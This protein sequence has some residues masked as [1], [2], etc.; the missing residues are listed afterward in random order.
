MRNFLALLF[1]C[2]AIAV[3]AAT[4]PVGNLIVANSI[5]LTGDLTPATITSDQNDYAPTNLTTSMN[6]RLSSDASRNITGLAGGSAGRTVLVH[7]VGSFSIVLRDQSSASVAANRFAIG[8]DVTLSANTSLLLQYDG[9]ASRW[10]AVGA[11]G[12]GGGG[13]AWGSI[14]GTLSNQTDLN[15]ALSGKQATG[16]YITALTGDVTAA[17][18]GSASATVTKINGVAMSGLATGIYKNTTGTGVP[19]IAVAGDFPTLNQNTTGSAATWTTGRTVSITGD[20]TYTS[21]SLNGSANVTGTATIAAN[22]VTNAKAAQMAAHTF[23]GNATGST[24][25]AQDLSATTLTAELNAMVGDSGSGGTKGLVPAPGAGDA[26]AGKFLK[27]DGTF[28]VPAGGGGGTPGG[29]DTQVQFNDGG[30]FGG[31]A[32]FTFNK[33][34]KTVFHDAGTG[35]L[36]TAWSQ[37]TYSVQ[38]LVRFSSPDTTTSF[39]EFDSYGISNRATHLVFIVTGGTRASPSHTNLGQENFALKAIDYDGSSYFEHGDYDIANNNDASGG[40]GADTLHRWYGT[41]GTSYQR[42]MYL[43]AR[44]LFVMGW[45][46]SGT[47]G[48]RTGGF[49]LNGG[50]SGQIQLQAPNSILTYTL[51]L[52]NAQGA[53]NTVMT[54]NGSGT[55]SWADPLARHVTADTTTAYSVLSTDDVV[56]LN[57]GSAVTATLP[58]LASVPV[59]KSYRIKNLG[60]GTVTVTRAS[61]DTIFVTSAVTSF[62]LMQGESADLTAT[63]AYW[64]VQ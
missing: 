27:A 34:N 58:S 48:V 43:N 15:T 35:S 13:V 45:V 16:N 23:K 33:T 2:A 3:N 57:N 55:L 56:T 31:N 49:N 41:T 36:P 38:P 22:A 40:G 25:N 44:D 50:T 28:A 63:S 9:T 37:S 12:T 59:G 21:G 26:A 19:S 47:A 53:A 1:L 54:N 10:R 14:T 4:T 46:T 39:L 8:A 17:G 11:P 30:A 18:P 32:A 20:V 24:A 62:D 6:L 5:T 60:A 29:S 51:Q 61:S 7:N 64:I 42:W 52:P